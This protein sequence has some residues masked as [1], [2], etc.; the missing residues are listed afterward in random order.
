MSDS[1][2]VQVPTELAPFIRNILEKVETFRAS[3]RGHSDPVDF[4]AGE[5]ELLEQVAKLESACVGVMLASLDPD[6]PFV[7]VGGRLYRRLN[8]LAENCYY[9]MRGEVVVRRH[10][11]RRV[12]IRNGP[13]VIPM[14]LRAGIVDGRYTPA[15]AEAFAR[16]AQTVPSREAVGVCAAMGVLPYSRSSHFRVGESVGDRWEDLRHDAETELIEQFDIPE[17][18]TALSVSVDRV[19]MPMAEPRVATAEDIENGVQNPIT[20]AWRMAFAAVWTLY[21]AEG[22]PLAAVRYAHVPSR[23]FDEIERSLRHDLQVLVRRRPGLRVVTL[24]DGAPEMQQLL[25]RVVRGYD[26]QAR[27]VDFWHCLEHL[28]KAIAA[29]GRYAPDLLAEW[30]ARLLASDDAVGTILAELR[31][32]ETEYGASAP[33]DLHAAVTYL[34]NQGDRMRYASTRAAG[35]PIGSGTVEATCKTVVEVR[36]KRAGSRWEEQG[37]QA[38]L[39]LRALATSEPKRWSAAMSRV[40]SSYKAHVR[41]LADL[42]GTLAR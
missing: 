29:T 9:P 26:V 8:Q 30:R 34:T 17:N 25:D 41:Q 33:E 22:T 2:S 24:A 21:D 31:G 42:N 15:A 20:V 14:D 40:L 23:G 36:M 38:I 32:W 37:A 11:Y 1:E 39:G 27:I 5:R 13:T 7:E 12:D 6:C 18:A 10:Y 35:L 19:S 3:A 4:Q 16:L 28:G